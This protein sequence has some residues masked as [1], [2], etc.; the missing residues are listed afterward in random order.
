MYRMTVGRMYVELSHEFMEAHQATRPVHGSAWNC[1]Y[2][3][4][5]CIE[6]PPC[7]WKR[8]E[9][10]GIAKNHIQQLVPTFTVESYL[11]FA[12]TFSPVITRRVFAL[13]ATRGTRY[14]KK[15]N[16]L[17]SDATAHHYQPLPTRQ[18]AKSGIGC[19]R[20]RKCADRIYQTQS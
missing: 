16:R 12:H 7:A 8:T 2:T 5:M 13:P 11:Q 9:V 14:K 6:L 15:R 4:W 10:Q 3:S 19:A 1:R 20:Y 18:A 17:I